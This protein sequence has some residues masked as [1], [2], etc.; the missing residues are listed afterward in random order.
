M[1]RALAAPGLPD[2]WWPEAVERIEDD[3]ELTP[4]E[5]D[6][7]GAVVT[8]CALA[9]AAT[10]SLVLDH[11]PG[12][13]RRALSLVP[14]VHVCVLRADAVVGGVPEAFA[15]LHAGVLAGRP[16]TL[17]SGPSATSDIELSRI[18][19]VAR[20]THARHRARIVS[21]VMTLPTRLSDE[22]EVRA[23][24]LAALEADET[25]PPLH[26]RRN[27]FAYPSMSGWRGV[28]ICGAVARPYVLHF[29]AL[30]RMPRQERY[31]VLECAGHRRS[32]LDPPPPGVP[33]AEGAVG[34]ARWGGAALADVLAH[35][36]PEADALEV[37]LVGADSGPFPEVAG[38][39]AFARSL[40]LEVALG[41][42]PILAWEMS[43]R[44]LPAEHGAPL[45]AIVPGWYAVSSVKWL[46]RIEVVREPFDGVFQALDY[47]IVNAASPAPGLALTTMPINA[48]LTSPP[49]DEPI[50]PGACELR[51]IAWGGE[52]GPVRV[53]V[54]VGSG[55]WRD[56]ELEAERG[57]FAP[58]RW[59]FAWR[60]R[61]GAHA[62]AVRATD[63]AG[64]VPAARRP[65]ERA[66]L[67]EQRG[68][69]RHG[70]GGVSLT[71]GQ[72]G[73]ACAAR[74]RPRRRGT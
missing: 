46:A 30:E 3:G 37:V 7:A 45:R 10:G 58:R 66:R 73:F 61:S 40:P 2:G 56:A 64:A 23:T 20:P 71:R 8:G 29:H 50:A 44:P 6:A 25:P 72:S 16:L 4:A 70:D 60:A 38:T 28:E 32:E 22:P 17:I 41:P 21:A 63:A 18:E 52:G 67:R 5:L 34:H 65:L 36:E 31:A 51:G 19:G 13:G 54:R 57:P 35:A 24:P 12:Q 42:D 33:W 1:T 43:G 14:D 15:R 26:F 68:A 59:S 69:R 48:L 49:T 9:I 39:H 53:E 47:R 27:H 55:R 62:I 74:A 11:G